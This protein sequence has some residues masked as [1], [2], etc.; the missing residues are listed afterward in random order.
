MPTTLDG[1]MFLNLSQIKKSSISF[2]ELRRHFTFNIEK[3]TFKYSHY[4]YI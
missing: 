2:A 4:K 1:F 3:K